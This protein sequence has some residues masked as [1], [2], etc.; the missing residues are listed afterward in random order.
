M[1][2][3]S[4]EHVKWAQTSVLA[5]S[6]AAIHANLLRRAALIRAL[7][8]Y[9]ESSGFV[10][11]DTPILRQFEDPTDNPT[12]VTL[13]PL[14]WPRLHLRTCPEE[15]TRR[16]ACV[17]G[18]AFEIGKSFRNERTLAP[19]SRRIHLPEFSLVEFYE[20][21]DALDVALER[22]QDMV[23]HAVQACCESTT[24]A[25]Q[26]S[27]I[28]FARPFKRLKVLDALRHSDD[29]RA[30]DFARRHQDAEPVLIVGEDQ[31]LHRLLE[32][33]VKPKLTDP[34][35]LTHFPK[36]ADQFPDCLVGNEVQ[37]AELVIAH[38]EVGEVGVLQ[39]NGVLLCNHAELAIRDRHH[40]RAVDVLLD[41]DYIAEVNNL[42]CLVVGGGMG[43]DRL[44][45]I[46]CDTLDI[47]DVVWYPAVGRL[48]ERT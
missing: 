19:R 15:Y 48:F 39:P 36:S 38:T 5:R 11:V 45:M 26:G 12:F 43:I 47:R 40:Q 44:L 3:D 7:R 18:K 10:E 34:T 27:Q 17:F 9:F 25:H 28:S 20:T 37:R 29:A 35:F 24:V 41:A 6:D 21:G 42:D 33:T 23:S 2:H 30:L 1:G 16:C 46:V 4:Q 22:M 13:G 8:S 14:G 32:E 31:L